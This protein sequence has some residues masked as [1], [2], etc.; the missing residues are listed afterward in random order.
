MCV[1]YSYMDLGVMQL[2]GVMAAILL[3]QLS[4]CDGSYLGVIA[5]SWC[6]SSYL[7]VMAAILV[8]AAI[9]V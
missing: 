5:V 8:S 1:V 6:D 9:L 4:W 7:G 3:W 2:L